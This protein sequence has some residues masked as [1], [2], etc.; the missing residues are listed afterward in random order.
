[1][2][3]MTIGLLFYLAGIVPAGSLFVGLFMALHG[4]ATCFMLSEISK[5]YGIYNHAFPTVSYT[6]PRRWRI[7]SFG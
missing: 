6:S 4:N 7:Q 3:V 2:I 5:S 1:M